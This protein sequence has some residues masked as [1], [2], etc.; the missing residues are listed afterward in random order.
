MKLM[1]TDSLETT[2][3]RMLFLKTMDNLLLK[4]KILT[5]CDE[6]FIN[7][8]VSEGRNLNVYEIINQVSLAL[9]E[10]KGGAF[11]LINFLYNNETD[12]LIDAVRMLRTIFKKS[13]VRFV[14][15]N[16]RVFYFDCHDY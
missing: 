11:K 10:I 12:E 13:K 2:D 16:K 3:G 5:Y 7:L 8:I 9:N 6:A 14:K 4:P 15:D 1:L